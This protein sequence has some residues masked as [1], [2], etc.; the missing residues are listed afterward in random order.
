MIVRNE[1]H[2][3]HELI[4]SVADTIDCWVIVDTGSDDGTQDLIRRLMAERGIPGE[5]HERPWRDFGHN[6]TEALALAQGHGDYIWMM[7]ADDVVE[8]TVDF[9]GLS[10]DGYSMRFRDGITYWR[11]QLFRS[12]VP[13]RYQGVLHEVA[14]CDEPFTES[15]LEGGYHIHSRRLGARNLDPQKYARDA[16]IL[17]AEVDRNPDDARSVFYLAQS[18]RDAGDHAR[19]RTWYERRAEMGGWDEEVYCALYQAAQARERLDEPWPVVQDA[20]LR[21]WNQRTTRSEPLHAIACRHRKDARYSLGHLFARLAADIP[22]PVADRLFMHNDVYAWRAVDEQAVCASWLGKWAETFDLCQRLLARDDI[23][24]EDRTRIAA[25]RDLALSHLPEATPALAPLRTA[26]TR[27]LLGR[28]IASGEIRLPAVPG[29]LDDYQAVCEQS[30]AALGVEFSAEQSGRLREVLAGQL[31]AAY[32]ASPRSEIVITHD[33]P[34]GLKVNYHVKAVWNTIG[35]TYDAWVAARQPPYFGTEPD[36]R[37]WA[38][39]GEA[40]DPAACPVLDVGAGTGRNSL[41]FARRGH[42]V[43]AVE[44]SEKFAAAL[45]AD[46][47]TESL[48]VRVFERDVFATRD[49]LRRDYPLML[50]SEVVSDFRTVGQ[51]RGVFELAAECLAPGGRLVFNVFL[52][53]GGYEPDVA[54]RELGQQVYTTIFTRAEVAAATAGLPL[55][56]MADDSV[57]DYEKEHLP[58]TAWP[59]TSWYAAWVSGQDVFDVPREQSPIEMRWLV[60]RKEV[61]PLHH[62]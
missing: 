47:A 21:A 39:A 32:A 41:A 3:I 46:A 52:P 59:P 48:P 51:L 38:L 12:G 54:A 60:Y 19:A 18:Y 31:A 27:R 53:R 43:D 2:V 56:L 5:L 28:A 55:K 42:P 26:M 8:G 11:R 14:V 45:R 34:V 24:D 9:S 17:Q 29:M 44:M 7:D 35:G 15:Q 37:V 23:P 61:G 58:A 33:S 50:L 1:A 10:A 49:D 40:A 13:W 62:P 22:M 20:Y 57:Y 16:E 30:F 36:A 25:N 6:R 4:A